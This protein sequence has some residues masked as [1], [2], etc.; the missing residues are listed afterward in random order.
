MRVGKISD[1]GTHPTLTS[2]FCNPR[3]KHTH[4]SIHTYIHTHTVSVSKHCPKGNYEGRK[5]RK[6]RERERERASKLWVSS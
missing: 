2:N 6:E 5:E 3:G 1:K 4:P